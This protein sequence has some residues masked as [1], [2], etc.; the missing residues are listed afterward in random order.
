MCKMK[1]KLFGMNMQH[2]ANVA[3]PNVPQF[4]PTLWHRQ[5]KRKL[6]NK[7]EWYNV[8]GNAVQKDWWLT[9]H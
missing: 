5:K 4:Q 3:Q 9:T 1:D 8:D 2:A 6:C 7:S